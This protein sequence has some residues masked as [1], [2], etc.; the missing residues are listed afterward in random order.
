M[1]IDPKAWAET[2][3]K[4]LTV[5][6]EHIPLERVIARHLK[7]LEELRRLGLTWQGVAALLVRAGARRAGGKLISADQLRVSYARLVRDDD[8]PTKRAPRGRK[9]TRASSAEI[10]PSMVAPPDGSAH[11][12]DLFKQAQQPVPPPPE[13]DQDVSG[14]ELEAVLARLGS[15]KPKGDNK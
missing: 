7:E 3:A 4:E 1:P 14:S 13:E 11:R 12:D 8:A 10:S 6:G 5:S 9:P 2:F 15:L